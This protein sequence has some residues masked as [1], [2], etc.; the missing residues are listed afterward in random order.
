MSWEDVVADEGDFE[1]L[2]AAFEVTGG[3][4][5]GRV[6]EGEARLM[7]QGELVDFA[8]GWLAANRPAR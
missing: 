5:T 6:G 4:R 7:R 3:T 8:A 1:R 2:G